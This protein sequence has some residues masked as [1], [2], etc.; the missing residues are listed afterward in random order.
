MPKRDKRRRLRKGCK[1]FPGRQGVGQSSCAVGNQNMSVGSGTGL[2]VGSAA[3]FTAF[4]ASIIGGASGG[5]LLSA[6]ESPSSEPTTIIQGLSDS[7]RNALNHTNPT[8]LITQTMNAIN[9]SSPSTSAADV[10]VPG[11]ESGNWWRPFILGG[12]ALSFCMIVGFI[13][14]EIYLLYGRVETPFDQRRGTDENVGLT[15]VKSSGRGSNGEG[16]SVR[17]TLVSSNGGGS[18]VGSG[19]KNKSK[20]KQLSRT[21]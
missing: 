14:Y 1:E 13:C 4:S 16:E 3:A 5:V 15:E 2:G 8:T 18:N 12:A 20:Q 7:I 11:G 19:G 21:R 17:D 10:T 6:T 9:S